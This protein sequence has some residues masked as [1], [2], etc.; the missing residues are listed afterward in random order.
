[1]KWAAV[2]LFSA[3][4]FCN[5]VLVRGNEGTPTPEDWSVHF[6]TTA[7]TQGH[8]SFPASYSG[9]NSLVTYPEERQSLTST[10]FLGRRLWE[11]GQFYVNP[12][13]SGGSGIS[14]T[15]GIAGYPNGE[16]YR[17]STPDVTGQISRIYLQQIFG[18]GG[19]KDTI[20]ADKN[21]LSDT[22]D[23]SRLTV[24]FG[25]FSLND[26]FDDDVYS[27]DPRT[28]FL[29][30]ALM[31]NG[32][33]DYA[34][35]TRGYTWGFYFEFNQPRWA[36]RFATVLEP[37]QANQMGMD[38]DVSH[39][40]G[41]NVEFEYRYGIAGHPGKLRALYYENHA[42]MGNYQLAVA[43]NPTAPDVISTRSYSIKYGLGLNIEQ[44]ITGDLG[45]FGRWGWDDGTTETWCFAEIDTSISFGFNL[46]G[47]LW[48]RKPDNVGIGFI[49]NG[50]SGDHANYLASG[51]Y[52]FIIGDGA[53]D[54]AQEQIYEIY[55]LYKPVAQGG[56]TADYQFVNHPADNQDR[57]PVSIFAGRAHYEF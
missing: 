5:G 12:E 24:I 54:Y 38:L 20:E 13:L 34:S 15:L 44:E 6:Q 41:D 16:I 42:H 37:D 3:A 28:Q 17:V 51:G 9:Q 22:P 30:W 29:N 39:A 2:F 36:L 52:G 19:D 11:G 33:W 18:F 7:V 26:F 46:T 40:H 32:A 8:G 55:Y 35:D 31:D 57:G 56:L 23:K 43:Q 27:H 4:V 21:Q 25:K 53:L 47:N 14:Q 45:F 1:M 50:L 49:S 10:L 48:G